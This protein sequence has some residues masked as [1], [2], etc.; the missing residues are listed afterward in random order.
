MDNLS[1][2]KAPAVRA[3]E[4]ARAR[5]LLLPPYSLDFNLSRWPSPNGRR[6]CEKRLSGPSTASGMPSAASSTSTRPKKRRT[7]SQLLVTMQA[8]QKLL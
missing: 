6:I 4:A 3:I 7:I 5:L 1:S 2:H 8:D